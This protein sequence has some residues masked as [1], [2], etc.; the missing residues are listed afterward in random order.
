MH[1][2]SNYGYKKYIK[3]TGNLE[4]DIDEEKLSKAASWDGLHGIITNKADLTAEEA[5]EYYHQLW[6]IEENFRISKHDLR[7]RPIYHWTKERIKAHIA[8]S[9][10]ALVLV[11]HLDYRVKMQ[12]KRLSPEV[13]RNELLHCQASILRDL[14]TNKRYCLPSQTTQEVKKIYQTVGKKINSIPFEIK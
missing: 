14:S 2:I 3:I 5:I 12:Y 1:L 13:I 10:M 9:F 11:R 6:Q 8:I 7:I 4:V